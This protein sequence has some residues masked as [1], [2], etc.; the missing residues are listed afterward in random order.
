[1][2]RFIKEDTYRGDGLNLYVY[3][4]N[5]P[6][7]YV[8][9]TGH[10]KT[11]EVMTLYDPA[12]YDYEMNMWEQHM[13]N[14]LEENAYGTFIMDY[15]MW[16]LTAME[17]NKDYVVAVVAQSEY[18]TYGTPPEVTKTALETALTYDFFLIGESGVKV[19]SKGSKVLRFHNKGTSE[20]IDIINPVLDNIRN[21]SALKLDE[22]HAF[23]DI[24]DNYVDSATH[25]PLKGGDDV[26]RDLY[27]IEG[28]L[29]GK[30]GIF[31]WIVDPD[32]SLGVTHRRF[33]PNIK[34]TGKPNAI[35][36]R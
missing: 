12:E 4:G 35:P 34:I 19:F 16:K 7:N 14:D 28:S 5:N 32:P 36:G 23:D 2:G 11:K 26:M 29:N 17:N 20:D 21:G 24:I 31:E 30:Q 25:F 33:I 8:D 15:V 9:P 6:V 22:M 3:V 1:M 13:K 27:Q 18:E 10:E